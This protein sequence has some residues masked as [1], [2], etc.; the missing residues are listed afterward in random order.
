VRVSHPNGAG[1]EGW[2]CQ[3]GTLG[4]V[5]RA[6]EAPGSKVEISSASVGARWFHVLGWDVV[7]QD[8]LFAGV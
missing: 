5:T 4:I 1:A 8:S 2:R 6:P 7:Q 3:P